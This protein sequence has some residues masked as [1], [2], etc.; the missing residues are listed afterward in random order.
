MRLLDNILALMPC[1]KPQ[2]SWSI[3]YRC[4]SGCPDVSTFLL[5]SSTTAGGPHPCAMVRAA[6]PL[7]ALGRRHLGGGAFSG[8]G[9]A[10][11]A[12]G[13]GCQLRVEEWDLGDRLVLARHGARCALEAG[14]YAAG[15]RGCGRGYPLCTRQSP[16]AGQTRGTDLDRE[17]AIEVGLSLMQ[18]ALTAG[19]VCCG[20]AG[21]L[22]TAATAAALRGGS[23]GTGFA[24]GGPPAPAKVD[25]YNGKLHSKAWQC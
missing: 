12:T 11:G 10:G 13:P 25:L 1:G 3:W 4:C 5:T 8:A 9:E 16:S 18:E 15:G 23:V 20:C 21:W 19:A 17:T 2:T 14:R 22:W 24:H 6:L 7:R